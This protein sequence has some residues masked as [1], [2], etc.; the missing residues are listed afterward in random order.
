MDDERFMADGHEISTVTVVGKVTSYQE[1]A[2]RVLLQLHDGTA[3]IEVCSWVDDV[4]AQA[5]KRVD[6]QVGKYVRVYGNLRTF[7]RRR[8]ITAFAV[9]PITDHNEVTYHMLKA[10]MEHLHLT[11]GA[12]PMGAAAGAAAGGVGAKTPGGG[13]AGPY[14]GYQ[15]AAPMGGYGGPAPAPAGPAGGDINA[16]L[17]YVYNQPAALQA[18]NGL[19]AEQAAKEL[20]AMGRNYSMAQILA[21]CEYLA[22][23]GVLYSTVTDQTF[24][25]TG[26]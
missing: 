12:P 24:K 18:P 8:N 16:D 21:A 7:E 23:E 10:I 6:W 19:H 3:S 4:D 15:A 1:Q 17:K 13:P 20:R 5:Q 25:S 11:K 26:S 22:A 2:T 14:G 9:K